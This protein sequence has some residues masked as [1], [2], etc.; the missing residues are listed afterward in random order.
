MKLPPGSQTLPGRKQV[1]RRVVAGELAGDVIGT[2]AEH[3][4]GEPLLRPVMRGGRRVSDARPTLEQIRA[5]TA[6][7][8][9]RLPPSLR[10][11]APP[12]EPY[13]VTVSAT[14]AAAATAAEAAARRAGRDR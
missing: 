1:F 13:P 11:T 7:Q 6:S 14:L 12:V 5:Y 3:A 9:R 8:L 10:M 4:E 2:A